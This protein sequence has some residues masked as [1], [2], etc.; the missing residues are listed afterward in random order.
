MS[1]IDLPGIEV[2]MS[3]ASCLRM[4]QFVKQKQTL[5]GYL[6]I[7]IMASTVI[8]FFPLLIHLSSNLLLKFKSKVEIYIELMERKEFRLLAAT[9]GPE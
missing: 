3:Y 2:S 4:S 9:M 6:R 1:L 7:G 5:E 8:M